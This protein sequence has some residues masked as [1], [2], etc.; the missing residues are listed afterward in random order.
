MARTLSWI[1]PLTWRASY[2]LSLFNPDVQL[3]PV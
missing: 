1:S 2:S 3:P